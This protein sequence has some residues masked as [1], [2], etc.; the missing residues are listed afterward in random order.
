MF[1]ILNEWGS[2]MSSCG[3]VVYGFMARNFTG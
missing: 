1:Y 2:G 3:E